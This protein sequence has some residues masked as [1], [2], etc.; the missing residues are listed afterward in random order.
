MEIILKFAIEPQNSKRHEKICIPPPRKR[1]IQSAKL[2]VVSHSTHQ[3]DDN[4]PGVNF[5]WDV[6]RNFAISSTTNLGLDL[7]SAWADGNNISYKHSPSSF[8][9]T[10]F[11]KVPR[12]QTI[13]NAFS[14]IWPNPATALIHFSADKGSAFIISDLTGRTVASGTAMESNTID[15]KDLPAGMYLLRRSLGSNKAETLKFTKL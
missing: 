2:M 12:T 1:L 3:V 15:V 4:P 7:L 9:S 8:A 10:V 6:A 11:R 5:A 14:S 13:V